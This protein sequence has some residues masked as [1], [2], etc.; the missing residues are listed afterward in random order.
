MPA[1]HRARHRRAATRN[2]PCNTLQRNSLHAT[3][4]TPHGIGALTARLTALVLEIVPPM[5]VTAPSSMRTTP[6]TCA[7]PAQPRPPQIGR[8]HRPPTLAPQA[9]ACLA[10]PPRRARTDAPVSDI[11]TASN[12]AVPLAMESTPPP[13]PPLVCARA[14]RT[15]ARPPHSPPFAQSSSAQAQHTPHDSHAHLCDV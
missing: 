7:Q 13:P 11:A 10:A 14:Q 6:P 1:P 12:S 4:P 5:N 2:I 9:S 8:A 15:A 3:S